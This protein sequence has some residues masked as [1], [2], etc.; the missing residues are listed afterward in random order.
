MFRFTIRD[1]LW[2]TVVVALALGWWVEHAAMKAERA[3]LSAERQSLQT[4]R[5]EL[6]VQF[7][8]MV[9]ATD[10]LNQLEAPITR[11]PLYYPPPPNSL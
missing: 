6:D 9:D 7:L 4:Q 1:V 2:L 3:A 10:R 11:F 5:R 8:R